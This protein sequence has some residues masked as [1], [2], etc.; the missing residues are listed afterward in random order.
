M[1][2]YD[3]R[4]GECRCATPA[5]DF[6]AGVIEG[7]CRVVGPRDRACSL[8]CLDEHDDAVATV[9]RLGGEEKA[10]KLVNA[11]HRAARCPDCGGHGHGMPSVGWNNDI[12]ENDCSLCEG[13]GLLWPMQAWYPATALKFVVDVV[14]NMSAALHGAS[15]AVEESFRQIADSLKGW[16]P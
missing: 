3:D 8:P 11:A 5:S 16:R 15:K 1:R 10:I 13:Y 12:I 7:W 9:H 2:C 4:P 14:D 6:F